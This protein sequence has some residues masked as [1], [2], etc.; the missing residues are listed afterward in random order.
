MAVKILIKRRVPLD[1][2]REM[3]TLFRQMRMLAMAQEGYI[4]GETLRNL[5]KAEEFLV[6]STWQS[7]QDWKNWLASKDR[8]DIQSKIDKLLGGETS[9]EIY[10]YGFTG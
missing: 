9:Y 8:K 3:I 6:I 2:A 5:E 4:S 10:H 7:S 1:K